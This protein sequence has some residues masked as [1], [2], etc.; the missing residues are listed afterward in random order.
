MAVR[1][2]SSEGSSPAAHPVGGGGALVTREATALADLACPLVLQRGP[3]LCAGCVGGGQQGGGG[4]E[5]GG[6]RGE[7]GRAGGGP[8]GTRCG[9]HTRYPSECGRIHIIVDVEHPL[10]V[11]R[12]LVRCFWPTKYPP[13]YTDGLQVAP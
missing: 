12:R 7:G 6:A 1:T 5:G 13:T 11:G 4:G 2:S 3:P 9:Q 10:E 8:G